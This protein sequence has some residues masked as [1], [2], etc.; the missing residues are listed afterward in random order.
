MCILSVFP[1][2]AETTETRILIKTSKCKLQRTQRSKR[3]MLGISHVYPV[4]ILGESCCWID[5][6]Q[7]LGSLGWGWQVF[8]FF[9][10]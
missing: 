6:S 9:F 2:G 8:D 1:Y 7:K 5:M 3:S 4:R 10:E